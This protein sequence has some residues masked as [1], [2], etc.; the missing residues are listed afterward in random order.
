MLRRT[1]FA[2]LVLAALAAAAVPAVADPVDDARRAANGIAG[3]DLPGGGGGT[4]VRPR[5]AVVGYITVS[6]QLGAPRP[7]FQLAG[8][9]A[10]PSLWTCAD[11]WPAAT[12]TVSCLP[13]AGVVS[14]WK[15]DVLHA[16]ISTFSAEGVAHTSLDC[17]GGAT[18]AEVETAVVSGAGGHDS[19]WSASPIIVT[20]FSCTVDAGA[21][22]A[23]VPDFTGGCGDPGA[24]ELG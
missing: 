20:A 17:D 14:E 15:C 8:A 1:S 18:P 22:L 19:K 9:L 6:H 7:T 13:G 2:A 12:Y 4:G 11:N 23:A 3:H 5:S 16:D 21:G 24:P 10:E